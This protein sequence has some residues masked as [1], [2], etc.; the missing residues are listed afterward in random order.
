MYECLFNI[1][2]GAAIQRLECNGVAQTIPSLTVQIRNTQ[3]AF[4]IDVPQTCVA[5]ISEAYSYPSASSILI[6]PNS[7]NCSPSADACAPAFGG[8]TS[9]PTPP[10]VEF[11][12]ALAAG[13]LELTRTSAGPPVDSCPAGETV[14]YTMTRK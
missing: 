9:C 6:T 14:R 11:Q 12:Y 2:F 4:V 5:T 1:D 13:E 3:G 7:N 8:N 10:P